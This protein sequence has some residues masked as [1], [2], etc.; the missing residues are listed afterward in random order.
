MA[1]DGVTGG[2]LFPPELPGF[3]I[4]YTWCYIRW[5]DV[6]GG[7][8]GHYTQLVWSWVTEVGCG[9]VGYER[10]V[11]YRVALLIARL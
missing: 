3:Y 1:S 8:Y 5:V 2:E 4:I 7:T 6:P 11:K 9:L 10:Q